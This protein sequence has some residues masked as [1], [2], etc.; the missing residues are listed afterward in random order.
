VM[1]VLNALHPMGVE[2]V[3]AAL[4]ARVV[5]VRSDPLGSDPSY[6][7]PQFR[8]HRPVTVLRTESDRG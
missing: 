6:T 2:V 3:T 4:R 1:N 8:L 7:Y 5:E